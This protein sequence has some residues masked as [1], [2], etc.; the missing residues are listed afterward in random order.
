MTLSNQENKTEAQLELDLDYQVKTVEERQE[1]INSLKD[2]IKALEV[3]MAHVL[4]DRGIDNT[5]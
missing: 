2:R 1:T 3:D 4:K 5:I